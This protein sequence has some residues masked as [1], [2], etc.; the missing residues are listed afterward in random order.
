MRAKAI[1]EHSVSASYAG[2]CT[3][4][5]LSQMWIYYA[6]E[7]HSK[8]SCQCKDN[9]SVWRP[10]VHNSTHPHSVWIIT[11]LASGTPV[12]A[13][14]LLWRRL[15][16]SPN[17]VALAAA[18]ADTVFTHSTL[19]R[20][21]NRDSSYSWPPQRIRAMFSLEWRCSNHAAGLGLNPTVQQS[22]SSLRNNISVFRLDPDN[23]FSY[24]SY[25]FS[26]LRWRH[27]LWA[28]DLLDFKVI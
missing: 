7:R 1:R 15:P 21:V 10:K 22:L 17:T 18:E 19:G 9:V 27:P 16:F 24:L 12:F 26:I 2:I 6:H 5:L 14:G 8:Y 11:A 25:D 4:A 23:V 13:K 20:R 3:T 28:A